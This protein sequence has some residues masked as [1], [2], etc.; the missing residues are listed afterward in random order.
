MRKR[1]LISALKA[2]LDEPLRC[3]WFPSR[4]DFHDTIVREHERLRRLDSFLPEII[5]KL[6]R[7]P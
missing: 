2:I 6:E 3:P 1:E 7:E 4:K 5:E